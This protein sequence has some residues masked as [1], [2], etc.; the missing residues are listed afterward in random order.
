MVGGDGGRAEIGCLL[1]SQTLAFSKDLLCLLSLL[2]SLSS[3]DTLHGWE[4]N[5]GEHYTVH[6]K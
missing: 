5:C 1:G 2:T 3:S 4:T 6:L